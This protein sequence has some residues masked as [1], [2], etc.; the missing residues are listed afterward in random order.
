MNYT[1]AQFRSI[2]NG[3]GYRDPIGSHDPDFPYSWDNTPLT[4]T[5]TVNAIKKFQLD[6]GLVVDGIAGVATMTKAAT[7]MNEIHHELNRVLACNIFDNQPFYS[8]RTIAAVKQ[9]Q[10][11]LLPDGMINLSLRQA[12]LEATEMQLSNQDQET[13]RT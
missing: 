7:V 8:P 12:L 3:L 2:L 6:Y 11:T 13:V 4:D 5:H 9:F 1:P 10:K